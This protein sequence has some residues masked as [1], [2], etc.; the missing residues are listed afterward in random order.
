MDATITDDDD[1]LASLSYVVLR[2]LILNF[3]LVFAVLMGRIRG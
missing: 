3:I 2:N 1:D